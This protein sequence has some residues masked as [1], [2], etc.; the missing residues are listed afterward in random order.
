MSDEIPDQQTEEH[1]VLRVRALPFHAA[2]FDSLNTNP[3]LFVFYQ[4]H[5]W[6]WHELG[7]CVFIT[8][9]DHLQMARTCYG[10]FS[11]YIER[12]TD[13]LLVLSPVAQSG[14]VRPQIA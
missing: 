10:A 6:Q 12:Q 13:D 14:D 2:R 11:E 3:V 4:L 8:D 7:V 9:K 1:V 5:R